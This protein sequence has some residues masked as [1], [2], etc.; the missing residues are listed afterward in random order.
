MKLWKLL[1]CIDVGLLLSIITCVFISI[2][3]DNPAI[4]DKLENTIGA[5]ILMGLALSFLIDWD[6]VGRS[7]RDS[8]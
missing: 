2:W 4:D 6:E 7:R 3:V 8:R 1:V 5:L